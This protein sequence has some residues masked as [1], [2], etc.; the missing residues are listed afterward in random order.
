MYKTKTFKVKEMSKGVKKAVK[1]ANKNLFQIV[2]IVSEENQDI[3]DL[4]V[5]LV[6]FDD[7]G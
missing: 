7:K 2:T 6:Y 5:V 4:E 3:F 1:F